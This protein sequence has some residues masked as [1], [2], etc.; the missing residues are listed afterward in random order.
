MANKHHVKKIVI[1]DAK[2]IGTATLKVPFEL[3]LTWFIC[4]RVELILH[5]TVLAFLK[6]DIR[7]TYMPRIVS[8]L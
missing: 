6:A 8:Q 7:S 2:Q 5:C 1:L 3:M 4:N